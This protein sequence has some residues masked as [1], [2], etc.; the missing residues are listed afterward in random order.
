MSR[1]STNGA[2]KAKL[3]FTQ[4]V[5]TDLGTRDVRLYWGD[6]ATVP[7]QKAVVIISTIAHRPYPPVTGQAWRA[8]QEE[9]PELVKSEDSF[10]VALECSPKSAVWPLSTQL[11]ENWSR[12]QAQA[13]F[14]PPAVL[15][16]A[17]LS[18]PRVRRV[19]VVRMLPQHKDGRQANE[20]DYRHALR[21]CFVALC[22]QESLE[23]SNEAEGAASETEEEAEGIG[24]YRHVVMSALAGTQGY[25][26]GQLL[27]DLISEAGLWLKASPRWESVD[28]SY[29]REGVDEEAAR[30]ELLGYLNLEPVPDAASL[31]S[32]IKDLRSNLE[33]TLTDLPKTKHNTELRHALEELSVTLAR[34]T[35]TV[36]E[37]GTASG[38]LAE[39]LVNWMSQQLGLTRPKDFATGIESLGTR[40]SKSGNARDTWLSQ[41]FKSYLHT[42]RILR[43]ESVHS[44][45]IEAGQ[46]P[47]VLGSDDL[48]VLVASL[49]RVLSL[50]QEWLRNTRDRIPSVR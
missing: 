49:N 45:G 22:A 40:K 37:V 46:F 42:L 36:T 18:E 47:D 2:P 15:V 29:W 27:R 12:L 11:A 24:P 23:L 33:K 13:T 3:I 10:R 19:F 32:L 25:D 39:A 8:L 21:G 6:I 9:F 30:N 35:Q 50:Q 43:N 5:K 44:Q 17:A 14:S 26:L 31:K 38:R 41:W 28:I 4:S 20:E 7:Q 1:G 34:E 16:S 48:I